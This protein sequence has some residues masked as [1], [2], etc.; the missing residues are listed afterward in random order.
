MILEN[1]GSGFRA[2][3]Y[4]VEANL[5]RCQ[6]LKGVAADVRFRAEKKV[7]EKV[8][9][10]DRGEWTSDDDKAHAEW[11]RRCTDWWLGWAAD[12]IKEHQNVREV[13]QQ[14]LAYESHCSKA[15]TDATLAELNLYAVLQLT[16]EGAR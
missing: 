1:R 15:V 3:F 16:D 6:S 4:Q 8:A 11:L 2:G 5:I 7:F 10:Q 14:S 12:V 9:K 13:F